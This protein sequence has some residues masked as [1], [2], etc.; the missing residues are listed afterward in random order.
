MPRCVRCNYGKLGDV[1]EENCKD[2]II[3]Y[4]YEGDLNNIRYGIFGDP[5]EREGIYTPLRSQQFDDTI[6]YLG[7]CPSCVL[8]NKQIE[9]INKEDRT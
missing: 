4:A 2:W 1:G 9:N 5:L 3:F 7:L 6:Y 8:S